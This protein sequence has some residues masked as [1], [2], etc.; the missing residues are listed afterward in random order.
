MSIFYREALPAK[1]SNLAPVIFLHG[2]GDS[3]HN[4]EEIGSLH[5]VATIGHRAIALDLPGKLIYT[6]DEKFG[7]EI[8]NV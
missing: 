6:G 2:A 3:S 4:W 1:E 8:F 7:N 5:L